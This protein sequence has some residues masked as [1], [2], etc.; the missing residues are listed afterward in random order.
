VTLDVDLQHFP[1]EIPRFLETLDQ[2]YDMV[3]GWR[4]ARAEGVSRRWPSRAANRLIRAISGLKLHDFGTTFRAYRAELADVN[5]NHCTADAAGLVFAGLFFG[6]GQDAERWQER[7]WTLLCEEIP[8]QVYP[9][10]VDFE[11]SVAYHRLQTGHS[12]WMC[13]LHHW[14]RYGA[15]PSPRLARWFD[16]LHG[17]PFLIGFTG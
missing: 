13:S 17:L 2:G 9:D 3:C 6:Q 1:E 10:G 12:F 4:H 11:A 16:P 15:R 14:L 8:R 5:G 7:G